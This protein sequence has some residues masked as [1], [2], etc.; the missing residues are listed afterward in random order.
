M[1][2]IPAIIM[3]AVA[4]GGAII[5]SNAASSA[6]KKQSNAT[7]SAAQLEKQ[8]M[9]RSIDAQLEMF[10]KGREDMAPWREA[11]GRA[12]SALES[13]ISGGPG[14]FEE[15]PGYQWA[16][17]QGIGALDKSAASRGRV[18][19]GGH[20]KAV[21]RY[22]T[23]LAS[24]DYDKFLG[25]YYDSLKP[26]QSLAGIGQ[27]TAGQSAQNALE[28]GQ[29]VGRAAQTGGAQMAQS[30]L[31]GGNAIASGYINQGNAWAKGLEGVGRAGANMYGAFGGGGGSP[32][33]VGPFYG[34]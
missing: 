29:G 5:Q 31:Y 13:R 22:G 14:E 24:Q 3:G 15:S 30:A 7:M 11:G 23:G 32:Q 4:I 16:L 9:E 10:Y 17:E 26:L 1:P 27:V 12:L 21:M 8:A 18:F 2:A 25:R 28:T 34:Y 20:E 33:G 19:A 6:A